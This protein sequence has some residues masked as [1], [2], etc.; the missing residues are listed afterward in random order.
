M[1]KSIVIALDVMG[2]DDAPNIVIEGAYLAFKKHPDISYLMF[3]DASVI[4]PMLSGYSEDFRKICQVMHSKERVRSTDQPSRVIRNRETS[5]SMAVESVSKGDAECVVSAGNTG[6]F[7]A[8]TLLR[9]RAC[10]GVDRPAIVSHMPSRVN[11]PFCM[12]DLGANVYATADNL[13]QFAVMGEA[14]ARLVLHVDNPS[15]GLLNIGEEDMKGRDEVRSAAT[16][17]RK[18]YPNQ[19]KFKGFV[20]GDRLFDGDVHVVVTDGF[21]GN[22]ALKTMEGTVHF[23][24]DLIRHSFKSSLLAK[25]GAFL[26][27]FAFKRLKKKIDPR[28]Y[29]GAVFLGVNG[30]AVKSHGGT[31]ALGFSNAIKVA[32]EMAHNNFIQ[33]MTVELEKIDWEDFS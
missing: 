22:V 27:I 13:V 11:Q 3:G 19:N 12:L 23:I 15:I 20:E 7:M 32:Y 16:I 14:F 1:S 26:S 10:G 30:I 29:N 18:I 33:R 5:M 4:K 21:T 28:L 25:L 24:T 2:G 8:L 6:A 9:L 31:D 17:L